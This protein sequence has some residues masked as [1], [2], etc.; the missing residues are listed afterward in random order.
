[1]TVRELL[2]ELQ[3]LDP[4]LEVFAQTNW[5]DRGAVSDVMEWT[6]GHT[7]HRMG[8]ILQHNDNLEL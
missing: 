1:M 4:E 2:A 7:G 6:N 5:T 8:V 3:R